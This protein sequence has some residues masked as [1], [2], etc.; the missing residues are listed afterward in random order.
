MYVITLYT[1]KWMM[2]YFVYK[3]MTFVYA[4]KTLKNRVILFRV[5]DYFYM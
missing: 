1:N 5:R 4:L 2:W 3:V